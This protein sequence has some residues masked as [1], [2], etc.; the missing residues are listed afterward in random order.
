MYV[1]V[2]EDHRIRSKGLLMAI[3]MNNDGRKE[4][5]GI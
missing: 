5:L 1:K 2:R 3:G 4:V